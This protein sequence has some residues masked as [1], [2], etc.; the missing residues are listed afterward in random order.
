MALLGVYQ[1]T[2]LRAEPVGLSLG[3]GQPE[4]RYMTTVGP[5]LCTFDAHVDVHDVWIST[6]WLPST[7]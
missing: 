6:G 5:L 4:I 2:S 3:F 1:H 7:R